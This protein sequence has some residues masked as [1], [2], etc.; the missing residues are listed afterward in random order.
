MQ[1]Q[2]LASPLAWLPS[3]PVAVQIFWLKLTRA[4]CAPDVWLPPPTTCP[5]WQFC[6]Q[7]APHPVQCCRMHLRTEHWAS[8]NFTVQYS[9][10]CT[11]SSK[12][13]KKSTGNRFLPK[14]LDFWQ[15]KLADNGKAITFALYNTFSSIFIKAHFCLVHSPTGIKCL[16]PALH[17]TGCCLALQEAAEQ[18]KSRKPGN[19]FGGLSCWMRSKGQ[20]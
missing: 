13:T 4:A 2:V 15:T 16:K 5:I 6:L 10:H 11:H 19:A 8:L 18:K 17:C 3:W 20:Y 12:H 7:D 9:V 1:V 14:H